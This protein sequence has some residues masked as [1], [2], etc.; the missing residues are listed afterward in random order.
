[1]SS[2]SHSSTKAEIKA[3]GVLILEIV[4]ILDITR[5]LACE[6]ELPIKLFCDN[7]SAAMNFAT[8]KSNNTV[9]HLNM[10][11]QFIRELIQD[12]TIASTFLSPPS[13]MCG[14]AHQGAAQER[15]RAPTQ[16]TDEGT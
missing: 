12:G 2:L 16:H 9:K 8:L 14:H 15:V 3:L 13:I 6:Q 5:F 7:K 11:I 10:R 1:V 4:H